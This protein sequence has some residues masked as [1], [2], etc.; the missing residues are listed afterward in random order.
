MVGPVG[1]LALVAT[2]TLIGTYLMV[3]HLGILGAAFALLISNS[4][5]GLISLWKMANLKN[6][7]NDPK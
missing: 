4:I 3:P 5:G 6:V 7:T 2:G 1:V